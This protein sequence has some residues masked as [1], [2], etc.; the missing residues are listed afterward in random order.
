MKNNVLLVGGAGYIGS[1][2]T[3]HLLSRG[4][5]VKCFDALIYSQKQNIKKF[6]KRKNYEFTFGDIRK[7]ALV[8]SS[9]KNI[10]DVVILAGLVG[11]PITKKYPKEAKEINF[12]ALKNFINICKDKN[13]DK[14][15]FIS[16]CSNYGLMR[17]NEIADENCN[18]NPLSDYAK[19][20][21]EIEKH[22]LSLKGHVDYSPIIL[23]FATA[24]GLSP[25]MRFDLTINH[26]TKELICKKL[27]NIYDVNTW[28]P[29]CHVN[30]FARLIEIVLLEKKEKIQFQIFNAGSDENNFT[31][32]NIIDEIV[33]IVPSKNIIFEKGGI[34]QRNYRVNFEKVQK[35]LNFKTR[36]TIQH[37]IKEI[38]EAINSNL[39][40]SSNENVDQL[41]NFKI[42]L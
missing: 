31:K 41:G 7:E 34:D 12:T 39:F 13:L 27:L 22:I 26:F 5:N 15:I 42:K 4:F 37:G 36:Y 9:L 3:E 23:R 17:N 18:L 33:K 2:L 14:L 1:V 32:K 8:E 35:V 11:D 19:H 30:D 29:Y 28:R 21:V 38:C 6:L 40:H 16:T 25:R 24:F 10:K 20:K